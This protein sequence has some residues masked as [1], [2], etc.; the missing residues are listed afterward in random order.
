MH[1]QG[2]ELGAILQTVTTLVELHQNGWNGIWCSIIAERFAAAAIPTVT[3]ISGNPPWIKWS[4]LPPD[5]AQIIKPRF[6]SYGLFSDDAWVG[7]IESDIST[8]VLYV[9]ADRYLA[10]GGTLG[11]FI[12]GTVFTTESSEGFRRFVLKS[13]NIPLGVKSVEDFRAISPFDDVSNHPTLIVVERDKP[14]TFPVPYRVWSAKDAS[15][16]KLR[17]FSDASSFLGVAEHVDHLAYPIPGGDPG[18]PW[19]VGTAHDH[20]VFEKV[21]SPALGKPQ[22][23]ARKGVTTDRNGVFWVHVLDRT[24]PTTVTIQN[25]A[26][27]GRTQGIQKKTGLVETEHVYPLLRG[28]GVSSFCAVPDPDLRMLIPQKGMHGD[29]NLVLSHPKTYKFLKAFEQVLEGRSSY[30]RYQKK[31]GHPFYSLWSTGTYTFSEYKVL[32]REMAGSSFAAAYVGSIDDPILGKRLV[33]PDHK[34]YF[35]PVQTED[36]AAY[37]TAFLNTPTVLR[38][39]LDMQPPC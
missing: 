25:A 22:Y 33:I 38:R 29:P 37:L 21:F 10:Q 24:S 32:W 12:T 17:S 35:I 6:Q 18:R 11:F 34:L 2:E 26:E 1:L 14:T 30:K 5:Y 19:L 31:Q 39:Y 7:G 4:H 20:T 16:R 23:Q 3:F 8:A 27:I 15:G 13:S 36:E 9:A 28:R